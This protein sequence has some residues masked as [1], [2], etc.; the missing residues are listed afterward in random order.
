MIVSQQLR[1]NTSISLWYLFTN[2]L[3]SLIVKKTKQLA[4]YTAVHR[5]YAIITERNIHK[6]KK[7]KKKGPKNYRLQ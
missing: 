5:K 7:K 6:P 2:K 1:V 4:T 3:K